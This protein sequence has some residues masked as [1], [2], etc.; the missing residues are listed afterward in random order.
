MQ[1]RVHLGVIALDVGERQAEIDFR[2]FIHG[3]FLLY[4]RGT[5]L[6]NIFE[7]SLTEIRIRT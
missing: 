3:P 4:R 7:L 2:L 1:M 5:C 6:W